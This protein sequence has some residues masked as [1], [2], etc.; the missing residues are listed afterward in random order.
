MFRMIMFRIDAWGCSSLPTFFQA[1]RVKI[2]MEKCKCV[3]EI[4][5]DCAEVQKKCQLDLRQCAP[6]G[7]ISVSLESKEYLRNFIQL[8]L[9]SCWEILMC[10]SPRN[11]SSSRRN[12]VKAP[13]SRGGDNTTRQWLPWCNSPPRLTLVQFILLRQDL[14][15]SLPLV[16][17]LPHY[18]IV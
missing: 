17:R 15:C 8:I 1:I 14:I 4:T 2:Q 18:F 9:I 12:T 16:L 6:S 13:T 5:K 3:C 10:L 7:R 11:G